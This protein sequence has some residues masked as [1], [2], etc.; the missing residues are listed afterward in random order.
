MAEGGLVRGANAHA[1]MFWRA[2]VLL[3]GIASLVVVAPQLYRSGVYAPIQPVLVPLAA[4]SLVGGGAALA[5]ANGLLSR[6]L[7]V[8]AA[9]IAAV[10]LA[11]L[12]VDFLLARAITGVIA[13]AIEAAALCWTAWLVRRNSAPHGRVYVLMVGTILAAQG[14][15]MIVAPHAYADPTVYAQFGR[16]LW[17]AAP[18]FIAGG[19]GLVASELRRTPSSRI[20]RALLA[21]AVIAAADLAVLVSVFSVT[22]AWT[23]VVS[24]GVMAVILLL[25]VPRTSLAAVSP[26]LFAALAALAGAG[27]LIAGSVATAGGPELATP[28]SLLPPLAALALC[29]IGAAFALALH[30]GRPLRRLAATL[31]VLGF[32]GG[33]AQAALVLLNGS[34][35]APALLLGGAGG[36]DLSASTISAPVALVAVGLV[37]FAII[38]RPQA[39]IIPG[40]SVVCGSALVGVVALNVLAFMLRSPFLF[41]IY[42][43]LGMP[44]HATVAF[45]ALAI[46]LLAAGI[47]RLLAAP[48]GDRLF[49]TIGALAV[50]VLLRGFISDAALTHVFVDT[51]DVGNLDYL[52]AVDAARQLALVM[53]V[54]VAIG[55]GLLLTRT[56]TLPLRA[57]LDAIAR[58]RAGESR[59]QADVEGEDEIGI[60]ARAF[61]QLTRELADQSDLYAA[62]R[63]AQAEL[64]EAIVILEEGEPRAWNEALASISGYT[65][66]DL[67]SMRSILELWPGSQRDDFAKLL[68]SRSRET[69]RIETS[70]RRRGGDP[71]DVEL[72]VHPLRDTARPQQLAILR[73]ITEAKR[74][75]RSLERLALHDALTGLPNRALFADRLERAVAAATRRGG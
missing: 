40:L 57:L 37:E 43:P 62:V 68:R 15:S 5:A 8:A 73:D 29:F 14:I 30:P 42:G 2:A 64:G 25:A 67:R 61:N 31:A 7:Q 53:L 41:D 13:Y 26:M 58:A 75:R 4:V 46:A 27:D 1:A 32:A 44:S 48:I 59:A 72:A 52:A 35:E 54:G 22:G 63:R 47:G 28:A 56:V 65:D 34:A 21:F 71:V 66:Q 51:E 3:G 11:V 20:T 10:P 38:A 33:A 6:R 39:R 17:L 12:A 36:S 50:L 9:L 24:Y 74:A 45:G 23:G 18:A 69:Y 16:Y 49:G 70:L 55:S 60:V 19:L